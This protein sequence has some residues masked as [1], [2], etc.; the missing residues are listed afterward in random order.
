MVMRFWFGLLSIVVTLL[1]TLPAY[2]FHDEQ[3]FFRYMKC[4]G[5][6][7]AF[8]SNGKISISEDSFKFVFDMHTLEQDPSPNYSPSNKKPAKFKLISRSSSDI[9]AEYIYNPTKTSKDDHPAHTRLY[10]NRRY[11]DTW[12]FEYIF[13]LYP[14]IHLHAGICNPVR[15]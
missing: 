3:Y 10:I 11:G 14:K 5:K 9:L 13:F 12:E 2:A 7:G 4:E 1:V 6:D 15:D 8:A